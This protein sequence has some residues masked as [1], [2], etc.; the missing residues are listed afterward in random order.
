MAAATAGVSPSSSSGRE[1]ACM[2][3]GSVIVPA[4]RAIAAVF[5]EVVIAMAAMQLACM[6][7]GSRMD[8][9]TIMIGP[10][11]GCCC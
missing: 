5:V 1:R 3:A 8:A 11:S 10:T 2:H 9:S 6:E 7:D 4:W